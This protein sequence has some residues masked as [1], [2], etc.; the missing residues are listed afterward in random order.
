MQY[1]ARYP[2]S[3]IDKN[4]RLTPIDWA[5]PLIGIVLA[6]AIAVGIGWLSGSESERR[7]QSPHRHAESAK[8]D[9]RRAC[10]EI[11]GQGEIFDCIYDKVETNEQASQAEQNLSAQQRAASSAL[12]S[13][14]IS[15]FTLL[16]SI[17]GVWY[18]KR[19]LDATLKA[20]EDT[21]LATHAMGD[22][23]NIART[24]QRAWIGINDAYVSNIYAHPAG[25]EY[26]VWIDFVFVLK[27]SGLS[28][29]LN[30]RSA[31][32]HWTDQPD[33]KNLSELYAMSEDKSVGGINISPGLTSTFKHRIIAKLPLSATMVSEK[34]VIVFGY[35]DGITSLRR[36]TSQAYWIVRRVEGQQLHPF[37]IKN[38]GIRALE[39]DVAIGQ[40]GVLAPMHEGQMY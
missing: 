21:S 10:A 33:R 35:N 27:N 17:I 34:C 40:P 5:F 2:M 31:L 39:D 12:S 28:P 7:Y 18:V 11:R 14:V 4:T 8:S 6:I 38:L 19:T 15:L 13:A 23:N 20:V 36:Q 37:E 22:A 32:M 9:A 24:A 25:E 26:W 1:G 30:I 16:V 3:Q 29:A